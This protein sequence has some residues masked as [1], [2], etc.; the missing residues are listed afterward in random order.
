MSDILKKILAVKAQEV[1]AALSA[2]SLPAIRAE[3]EQAAPVRD[4]VGAI[5]SKKA[6]GKP[7]GTRR[8][9]V[10][11]L[12]S[13]APRVVADRGGTRARRGA[14]VRGACGPAVLAGDGSRH[15][16]A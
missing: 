1:A 8:G 3:A 15:I 14:G 9:W 2:K 6:A 12:Y 5:R 7:G 11:T 10:G 16:T 13:L 4:F